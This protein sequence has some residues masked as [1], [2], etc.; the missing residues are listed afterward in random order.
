MG[1]IFLYV[2]KGGAKRMASVGEIVAKVRLEGLDTVKK[3]LTDFSKKIHDTASSVE[4]AGEKISKS[5]KKMSDIGSTLTKGIS[6]PLASF[7]ILAGK[8]ASDFESSFAGVKKTV[9]E[10]YDA[11]G[12]LTISYDDLEKG[13]RDMAK[14]LPASANEIAGVAESAGQLGIKTEN[15]LDFTRTMIDLG[16][17]TNMSSEEA[18]T[19]LAQLANI[20]KMPQDSFDNLGSTIVALGNTMATTES[21]IVNMGLRLAGTGAQIGLSE[22]QIMAL[23]GTMSSLGINAE[24]GGGSMSRVLQKINTNVL[25]GS[26]DLSKFAKIA[27]MSSAEFTEAWG[28]DTT[29]AIDAFVRGLGEAGASGEDVTTILKDLGISSTQEIDTLLRLS[30]AG[31]LL[32]DAL[33]TASVAW[34]ENSALAEEAGT[35]YETTESKM[36]MFKNKLQD[37]MITLGEPL[38][39]AMLSV[40][41]ALEPF[42]ERVAELAT[43]F[44]NADKDTQLMIIKIGAFAIALGPALSA[45]GTLITVVG[46]VITKGGA[47][48]KFFTKGAD[49]VSGFVKMLSKI[50]GIVSTVGGVFVKVGGLIVKSFKLVFVAIKAVFSFLMANPFV[51]LGIAVVAL[52]VLIVKNW[53]AIKEITTKVWGMIKDYLSELWESITSKASEVWNGLK[54]YL[55]NLWESISNKVSDVWGGVKTFFSDLWNSIKETA[56]T[57]W[58]FI[59]SVI[60]VGLMLIVEVIK[61]AF[62]LITLPFRFIWENT[63]DIVIEAWNS[64]KESVSKGVTA[65]VEAI[66]EFMTPI[67]QFFKDTWDSIK[68]STMTVWTA[69][70]EF[71]ANTWNGISTGVKNVWNS[72]KTFLTGIWNGIKDVATTVWTAVST[73]I[74]DVWIRFSGVVTKIWNSIKTFLTGVWNGIKDVATRIWTAISTFFTNTWNAI[75]NKVTSIWNSIKTYLTNLWNGIKNI[76]SS[77]WNGIKNTIST[78]V[79]NIKNSVVNG[80]NAVKSSVTTIWNNVKNA[81]TKPINQARDAVSKAINKIKGFMDFKWSL[82]KLKMPHFSLK[83]KFSLTPPSVPKMAVDW[84]ATGGIATGASVVGIGEAGDEAIV[85]LSNKNRMR[86]FAHAISSMMSKD[87]DN[88]TPAVA[89]AT[90]PTVISIQ[91]DGREIARATADHMDGELRGRRD[92]KN[93]SRGGN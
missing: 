80:F 6:I 83:G 69:I 31:E 68:E 32:G 51:L 47:F 52:V 79:T 26:K 65:I 89:V 18:S 88:S 19:A 30:G 4:K 40:M 42:I 67:I 22:S 76:A 58:E 12:N 27:G 7:G 55:S 72:I 59:T 2:N 53:D 77:I 62:T 85:P 13:I 16:E 8:S 49:G 1:S 5:G 15:V 38:L 23:A 17:S 11:N 3:H 84:Y 29:Q 57:A 66:T 45:L 28:D 81:I 70:K 61:G 35:R 63:K 36:Q 48:V 64:I 73:F 92:S 46:F 39:D 34:A 78:I 75:K 50:K 44:A 87:N 14:V 37:I 54:D 90:Q 91:V 71:F 74:T 10:L 86:P 60:T 33:D 41:D 43:S 21:D 9:D 56:S 93:R 20:T 24:A 25:S 82:P